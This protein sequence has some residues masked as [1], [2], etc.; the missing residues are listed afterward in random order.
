MSDLRKCQSG[1]VLER[2][3]KHYPSIAVL[4]FRDMSAQ[5]DQEYLCDGVAEDIIN[6]L[7]HLE[8]LQVVA[9][10]SAFSFRGRDIDIREIGRKLNVQSLLEGSIQ[11][12]GDRLRITAQLINVSDGYHLWSEKYDRRLEDVFAIQDEIS[13]AIVSSLKVKLLRSEKEKLVKRY[14]ENVQAYTLYLIGR[15]NWNKRT[16]EGIK[17]AFEYYN[18]AIETDPLYAIAYTGISDSYNMLGYT[19]LLTPGVAFV[20]AKAAAAKAL[21]IDD[22]LAEAHTSLAFAYMYYDW[23]W[24]GAE[25]ELLRAIELNRDYALAR[26]WYA[27]YLFLNGRLNECIAELKQAQEL[28][29]LSPMINWGIGAY[30]V[31]TGQNDKAIEISNKVLAIEPNIIMAH[32]TLSWAYFDKKMYDEAFAAEINILRLFGEN[33]EVISA[34]KN[35]YSK[36]GYEVAL[37]KLYEVTTTKYAGPINMARKCARFGKINEALHWLEKALDEREAGA[38][39]LK[40]DPAFTDMRSDSKFA[41]LLSRIGLAK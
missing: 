7:T 37:N 40:V 11:K 9:R 13:M 20:K 35:I 6:G 30:F 21:E 22:S 31:I 1:Q 16:E 34:L 19:G 29:P 18:R 15:Y 17:E 12:T 25:R 33:E 24:E 32:V 39:M 27:S 4:P 41:E 2:P 36:S 3:S 5:R 14:T 10:T 26:F 28:D 23:N 38:A 8:G